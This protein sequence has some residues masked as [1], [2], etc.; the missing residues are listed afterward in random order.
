MRLTIG[1][2][3]RDFC[4]NYGL[5]IIRPWTK[6]IVERLKKDDRYEMITCNLQDFLINL[7]LPC[8]RLKESEWT[9]DSTF[10]LEKLDGWS[11]LGKIWVSLWKCKIHSAYGYW[12]TQ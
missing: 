3:L 9:S 10:L 6:R 4:N 12:D 7:S 1:G 5:G 11:Y 8:K 2:C